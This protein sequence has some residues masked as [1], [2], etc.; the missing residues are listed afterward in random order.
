MDMKNV[1]LDGDLE[2]QI[3]MYQPEGF[4]V[5]RKEHLVC[6]L[7]KYLDGLK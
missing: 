3:Y 5:P 4:Q 7:K 6:N 2:Q 1:F